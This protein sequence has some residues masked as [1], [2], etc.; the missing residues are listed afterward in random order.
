MLNRN[1]ICLIIT[2]IFVCAGIAESQETK[3]F[4]SVQ[5]IFSGWQKNYGDLESMKVSYSSK[6]VSAE[7]SQKDPNFV[8]T[9]VP[10]DRKEILE[11]GGKFSQK[12]ITPKR[13]TQLGTE[14]INTILDISFDGTHQAVY[15]PDE[16]SAHII[17]GLKSKM[18]NSVK[19]FFL[20]DYLETKDKETNTKKF[21]KIM[22]LGLYDPNFTISVRPFLENIS[23]QMCHV[24]ELITKREQKDYVFTDWLAHE[25][26][27]LPMK[28]QFRS[29][30]FSEGTLI[31][32]ID[33]AKTENGGLWFPKKAYITL[34]TPRAGNIKQE[35][36]VSEF[37][38]NIKTTPD[39][40][41]GKF[42]NG[43]RVHDEELGLEYTVG[44]KG[45]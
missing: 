29:G 38:P 17:P 34:N 40:F 20:T 24:V 18:V 32:E 37:I 14:D 25:R 33:F 21:S 8:K 1:R 10:W 16:K 11:E 23:G 5:E 45:N 30:S 41:K 27:M 3:S 12:T 7:P 19:A 35:F 2:A 26:G 15:F 44:V 43:T 13:K 4:L 31:E 6:I 28:S 39:D 42:P 22:N 9:L 36:N